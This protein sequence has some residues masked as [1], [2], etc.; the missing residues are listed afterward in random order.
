MT[1]CRQF[2][3][4]LPP[5]VDGVASAEKVAAVEAHLAS[6]ALCRAEV[7]AEQSVRIVLRARAAHLTTPAP[8][9]LRTRIAASLASERAPSLGWR[10]RLTAFGAAA[11]V[12]L[13]LVTAF[14]FV[15]PRSNVLFAA[16]LAIDHV[17]CFVVEIAGLGSMGTD[18]EAL[19][20]QYSDS[21][22]WNVTVPPSSAEVGLTLIAARRCPFW[23]GDHAHLLYHAGDKQVSLYVTQGEDRSRG[24]LSVFGHVERI[25]AAQGNSYVLVARGLPAADLDRIGNYLEANTR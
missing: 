12:I 7:A 19:R 24:E 15:S 9:G 13:L 5:Y 4:L 14:E 6:C 21:Y 23:L 10:G 3:S 1:D 17:R 8:L 22:G 20:Q 18:A 16:Q 11:A 25:W 2:E